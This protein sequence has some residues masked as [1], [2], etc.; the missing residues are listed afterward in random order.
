MSNAYEH[1][2]QAHGLFLFI[3][4]YTTDSILS[5]VKK[6]LED[7]NR[8][9]MHQRIDITPHLLNNRYFWYNNKRNH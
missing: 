6:F 3:V 4:N 5:V 9:A 2:Q 7:C 8:G 1:F